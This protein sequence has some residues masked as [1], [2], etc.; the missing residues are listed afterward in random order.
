MKSFLPVVVV[1]AAA[2]A[3]LFVRRGHDEGPVLSLTDAG[4]GPKRLLRYAAKEGTK[5]EVVVSM[6]MDLGMGLESPATTFT[7]AINVVKVSADGDMTYEFRFTDVGVEGRETP[8]EMKVLLGITGSAVADSRGINRSGSVDIPESAPPALKQM[9]GKF[10][11]QLRQ[12]SCPF[13][14]EE[15]G[16]GATWELTQNLDTPAFGLRQTSTFELVALEGNRGKLKLTVRQSA[17]EQEMKGLPG[18]AKATLKSLRSKGA[19]ELEF[20]LSRPVPLRS[21]LD[22]SSDIEIGVKGKTHRQTITAK[23]RLQEK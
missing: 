18:G 3:F 22:L 8:K 23:I 21:F 6:E 14:D 7:M 16:I 9:V 17:D 11:E 15:V 19:G 2:A 13:P 1:V 12:M 10:E 5:Y 4:S 20:D